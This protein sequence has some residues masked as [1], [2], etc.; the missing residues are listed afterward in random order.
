M[1]NTRAR[2]INNLHS[3]KFKRKNDPIPGPL[4]PY[5]FRVNHVNWGHASGMD[6]RDTEWD[7]FDR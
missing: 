7:H 2:I 6:P 1:K 4:G 5:P 3:V